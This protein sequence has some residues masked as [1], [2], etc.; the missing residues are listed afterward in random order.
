MMGNKY[1][2]LR[3][4]RQKPKAKLLI[5]KLLPSLKITKALKLK[6]SIPTQSKI[7]LACIVAL[8]MFTFIILK[9]SLYPHVTIVRDYDILD[10]IVLILRIQVCLTQVR[11][12][13]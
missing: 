2:G 8:I 1:Q 13:N 10:N 6:L 11:K 3:Y 7:L 9:V 5:A 12:L 4:V